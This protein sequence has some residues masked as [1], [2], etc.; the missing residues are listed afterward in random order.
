[1]SESEHEEETCPGRRSPRRGIWNACPVVCAW[2]LR[3]SLP[4]DL[5]WVRPVQI[6]GHVFGGTFVSSGRSLI[7][8]MYNIVTYRIVVTVNT[9]HI[10]PPCCSLLIR[11]VKKRRSPTTHSR[12]QND[13]PPC[14]ASD[15]PFFPI[16]SSSGERAGE[17]EGR[18][19]K[20]H[21]PTTVH[22]QQ[23]L[24]YIVRTYNTV[25]IPQ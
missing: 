15:S 5:R 24:L 12:T 25:Y 6:R 16:P 18:K 14:F 19:E 7:C 20:W 21:P 13:L 8:I 1:M 9:Y 2:R 23:G 3:G 11:V 22:E 17:G 10:H 4:I